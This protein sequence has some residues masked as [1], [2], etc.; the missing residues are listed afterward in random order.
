MLC[1]AQSTN[2]DYSIVR[3]NLDIPWKCNY[4]KYYVSSINTKAN[5]LLTTDDDY[6]LFETT[7]EAIRIEFENMYSYSMNYLVNYLNK[8]QN[9]IQFKNINHR[10][11]SL[12]SGVAV[13]FKEGSQSM[14]SK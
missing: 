3:M 8:K 12:T 6:L 2:D 11:I 4:V 13:N 9:T 1:T 7:I 10:T 14:N 5:I